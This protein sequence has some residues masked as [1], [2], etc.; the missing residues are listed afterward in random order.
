MHFA[1]TVRVLE[2][3]YG[4]HFL[5]CIVAHPDVACFVVSASDVGILEVACSLN[6]IVALATGLRA[7]VTEVE[8]GRFPAAD[9]ADLVI[10]S[11]CLE[12]KLSP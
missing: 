5:R 12:V 3:H 11:E 8:P 7:M 9:G 2:E 10:C 1:K 6:P 4:A